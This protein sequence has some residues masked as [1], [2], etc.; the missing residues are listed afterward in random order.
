MSNLIYFF[1]RFFFS[2][3]CETSKYYISA[4]LLTCKFKTHED[5]LT[6][7]GRD[8]DSVKKSTLL[9]K[10]IHFLIVFGFFFRVFVGAT[11]GQ[12]FFGR[13]P[14]VSFVV[15][16]VTFQAFSRAARAAR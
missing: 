15:P 13:K 1:G 8:S 9:K 5:L 10:I 11:S 2:N 7:N 12:A 14:F 4:A 6:L 16:S 3:R